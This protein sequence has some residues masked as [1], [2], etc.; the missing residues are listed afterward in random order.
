MK[1]KP[2]LA[3]IGNKDLLKSKDYWFQIKL[4]GTRG[5]LV[6]EGN[7]LKMYNR[8]DN[9]FIY[10]Y[11]EFKV[12]KKL[13]KGSCV[14]DGE[15]IVYNEKGMPNFH[16]LQSREQTSNKFKIELMSKEYPATYVV[17]DVL[18]ASG[19]DV[20]QKPIEERMKILEKIVTEGKNLQIIS[21][22]DNG[23]KLWSFVKKHRLEGV[24]AKKKKSKYYEGERKPVWMKIKYLKRVHCVI[25]GFTE[26]HGWR[27][28]YFGAL[29]LGLYKDKKLVNVG[30]VGTGWSKDYL[31]QLTPKLKELE[32]EREGEKHYIKPKLTC[33]VEYLEVT[34]KGELRAPSYKGLSD[35]P[36]KDC[37]IDQILEE[38]L[39]LT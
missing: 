29:M 27:K 9:E 17:F 10:R 5:I 3:V 15:V 11:P 37:T 2:M 13:I 4:D 6:K 21:T 30:R 1:Y 26:G 39:Y 7:T 36:A 16:L 35:W 28:N 12:F 23:K 25:T 32:K 19:K 31:E 8:R 18:R 20:T 34:S 22:T 14:L 38:S 33:V 24:M